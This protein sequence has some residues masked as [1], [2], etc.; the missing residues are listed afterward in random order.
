M[1]IMLKWN[2]A[3]LKG[4]PFKARVFIVSQGVDLLGSKQPGNADISTELS[5]SF[6][7]W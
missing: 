2:A 3:G 6:L 7:I 4:G 5:R 1:L